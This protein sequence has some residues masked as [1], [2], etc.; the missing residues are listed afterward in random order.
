MS[1]ETKFRNFVGRL[2]GGDFTQIE[3]EI[4]GNE[5]LRLYND[6]R[7]EDIDGWKGKSSFDYITVGDYIEVTK[8][9]KP[10]RG[11]EPKEVKTKISLLELKEIERIIIKL[12]A[13]P[14]INDFL[15]STQIAEY[16]YKTPWGE[17]FKNRKRHNH[18]TIILNVLEK[19]GIIEY[20]E[21]RVYLVNI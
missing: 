15:K 6:E 12:F 7:K 13:I 2:K 11:A 9:Q 14:K 5:L 8:F 3:L 19:K 18:F 20:K 10:E 16:Y 21:S 17:V 4:V 1:F